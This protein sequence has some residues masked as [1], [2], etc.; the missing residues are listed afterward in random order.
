MSNIISNNNLAFMQ[1]LKLATVDKNL[2]F[3]VK[4]Q[5][6]ESTGFFL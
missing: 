4:G 3:R 6:T 1:M 5:K 2:S